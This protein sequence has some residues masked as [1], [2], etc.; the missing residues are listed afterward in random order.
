[1]EIHAEDNEATNKRTSDSEN[2]QSTGKRTTGSANTEST[3]NTTTSSGHIEGKTEASKSLTSGEENA[4]SRRS[5]ASRKTVGIQTETATLSEV[6]PRE[7]HSRKGKFVT[8]QI[9]KV[10]EDTTKKHRHLPEKLVATR[11]EH[12][13]CK[14]LPFREPKHGVGH[15]DF[16]AQINGGSC[17]SSTSDAASTCAVLE[18]L[19][20]DGTCNCYAYHTLEHHRNS[21]IHKMRREFQHLEKLNR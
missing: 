2:R 20:R 12:H 18:Q 5:S 4:S 11:V 21:L 6:V 13:R 19:L 17:G 7:K 16:P 9:A 10:K 1:M 14:T 3:G 8:T 15:V